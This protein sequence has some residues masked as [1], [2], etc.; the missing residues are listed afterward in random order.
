VAAG[1]VPGAARL[2]DQLQASG[3]GGVIGLIV[4]I[5]LFRWIFR[6]VFGGVLGLLYGGG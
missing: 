1:L 4:A 6:P 2:R 5:Y 3:M